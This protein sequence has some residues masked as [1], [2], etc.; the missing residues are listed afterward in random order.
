MASSMGTHVRAPSVR[1]LQCTALELEATTCHCHA[2]AAA[3]WL[4]L[5][6]APSTRDRRSIPAPISSLASAQ[7]RSLRST[8]TYVARVST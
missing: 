8:T 4:S 5:A 6:N 2:A 1:P 7:T 3:A